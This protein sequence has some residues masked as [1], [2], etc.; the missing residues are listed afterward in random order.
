[1]SND[2]P[3]EPKLYL[4]SWLNAGAPYIDALHAAEDAYALPRNLLARIAFE[5]SHFRSDIVS[6]AVK[7]PAGA[8]GIMQLL[9]R[10]F[11]GA[12]TSIVAD[13]NTAGRYLANLHQRF[14]DWQLSLAAYN[15]GPGNVDKCLKY[16]G[17]LDSMPTETQNYVTQICAD[18]WVAGSLIQKES[19]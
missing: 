18:V 5:E 16:G 7:S 8:V 17:T 3:N 10:F 14:A 9:P 19:T 2:P 13:I 12:G 4:M 11:P 15:W 6:G 1:M